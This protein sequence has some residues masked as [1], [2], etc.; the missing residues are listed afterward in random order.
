MNGDDIYKFCWHVVRTD[1][2]GFRHYWDDMVIEGAIAIL[3]NRNIH[4]GIRDFLRHER[5]HEIHEDIRNVFSLSENNH[6]RQDFEFWYDAENI[7]DSYVGNN[8]KHLNVDSYIDA[9]KLKSEGYDIREVADRMNL[10]AT[11]VFQ[12]LKRVKPLFSHNS[13]LNME[14]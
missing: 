6:E 4:W 10:S 1:Y 5:R 3:E 9:M 14:G 11:T 12:K 13:T 8:N 2:P 7:L